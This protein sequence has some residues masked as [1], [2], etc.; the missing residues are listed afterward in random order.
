MHR[1]T[2]QAFRAEIAAELAKEAGIPYVNWHNAKAL[3]RQTA[4]FVKKHKDTLSHGVELAGLGVLAKPSID[5]LRGK[6]VD[7]K[8]K[9]KREVQ[10]LGLLAAPSALHLAHS[11]YKKVR[12]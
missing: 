11:V 4:S 7:E 2:L 10:G 8:L 1:L 3:G 5:E 12:P 6:K 9:A